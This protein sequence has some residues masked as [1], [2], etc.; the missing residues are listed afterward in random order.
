MPHWSR[1]R[2][3]DTGGNC[4]LDPGRS[5]QD[6][7]RRW[8]GLAFRPLTRMFHDRWSATSRKFWPEGHEEHEDSNAS[9]SKSLATFALVAVSPRRVNCTGRL[10]LQHGRIQSADRNYLF[11][12]GS[13][14]VVHGLGM[15]TG[16]TKAMPW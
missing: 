6:S 5:D 2:D 16:F 9:L 3:R 8:G 4:T 15:G 1:H 14:N 12:F 11:R 10:G 13:S 7:P